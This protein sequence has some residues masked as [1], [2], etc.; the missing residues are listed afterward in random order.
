MPASLDI[1]ARK[2]AIIEDAL[3]RIMDGETLDQIGVIHGITG[4]TLNT[5]LLSLGEE[6]QSVRQSF[7]DAKLAECGDNIEGADDTFPLARAREAFK[8]WQ[9]IAQTRDR[10]RYGQDKQVTVNIGI[11]VQMKQA[12]VDEA[13]ELLKH[14]KG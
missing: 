5:W 4:R 10:A 2:P 13:G 8:Y 11:G 9:F 12:L 1:Q 7:I 6:Y 14:L 3:K